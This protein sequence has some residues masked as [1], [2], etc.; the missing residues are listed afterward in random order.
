MPVE[1]HVPGEGDAAGHVVSGEL[2]GF[3][4]AARGSVLVL[5]DRQPLQRLEADLRLARYVHS[6][7]G[8]HQEVVHDLKGP[9]NVVVINLELL[10]HALGIGRGARS[11]AADPG[12]D[13]DRQRGYIETVAKELGKIASS[14][15]NLLKVVP[16]LATSWP[17][18]DLREI[19]LGL[20]EVL[21]V[22]ARERRIAID[23]RVPDRAVLLTGDRERLASALGDVAWMAFDRTADDGS[24]PITLET[25]DRRAHLSIALAGEPLTPEVHKKLFRLP[26]G[27]VRASGGSTRNLFLA[28]SAL[29]LHG[30]AIRVEQPPMSSSRFALEIPLLAESR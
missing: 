2:Y 10:K 14:L 30:G 11:S 4:Q 19:V 16:P 17:R 9:L 3:D 22:A 26:P 8:F 27:P 6:L 1:L 5:H 15:D 20:R 13:N 25:I 28:R 23:V 21:G 7:S 12:H 24:L 18:F 29:E